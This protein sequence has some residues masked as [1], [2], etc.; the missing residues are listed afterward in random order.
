MLIVSSETEETRKKANDIL[1]SYVAKGEKNG[2]Q[3]YKRI[4]K[5]Y[6]EPDVFLYYWDAKDGEDFKGW[7][8]APKIGG[9]EVWGRCVDW[10]E[11][12]RTPPVWGWKVPW[13]GPISDIQ[14]HRDDSLV[15]EK[16]NGKQYATSQSTKGADRY[17]EKRELSHKGKSHRRTCHRSRSPAA[18]SKTAADIGTIHIF[19]HL[20]LLPPNLGYNAGLQQ[21]RLD[22]FSKGYRQ[23]NRQGNDSGYDKELQAKCL[24]HEGCTDE[25]NEAYKQ[26]YKK[27]YDEAF[28][29]GEEAGYYNKPDIPK[30][31]ESLQE[32]EKALSK[33]DEDERSESMASISFAS[34]PSEPV[35]LPASEPVTL[36]ASAPAMKM[37]PCIPWVARMRNARDAILA[38]GLSMSASPP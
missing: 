12:S 13:S 2:K 22:G 30:G 14:V 29:K 15:F 37:G 17:T 36:P 7:W 4:R 20:Q 6:D 9:N 10:D 11:K 8:F 21:G 25:H 35:M 19:D 24:Y 5:D 1:G 3:Y 33:E 28:P 32:N 27:G 26:G 31:A 38:S 34:P 16:A 18:T 23:G